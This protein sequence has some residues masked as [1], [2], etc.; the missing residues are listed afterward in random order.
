MF[1]IVFC[2][3]LFAIYYFTFTL[4]PSEWAV[5]S[6]AYIHCMDVIPFEKFPELFTLREYSNTYVPFGSQPKK[7]FVDA[8]RVVS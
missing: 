4:M 1:L 3:L 7:K 5:N 2:Y 8:S 6:G